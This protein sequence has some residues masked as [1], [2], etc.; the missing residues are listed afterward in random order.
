M[1]TK[2]LNENFKF[3][4]YEDSFLWLKNAGVADALGSFLFASLFEEV[5]AKRNAPFASLS[6]VKNVC[7]H[8]KID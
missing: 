4:R 7:I 5:C 1:L 6:V 3:N 8:R 2:N